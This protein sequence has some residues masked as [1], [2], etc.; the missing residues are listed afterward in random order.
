MTLEIIIWG[1]ILIEVG[2]ARKLFP[3]E[4]APA[5]VSNAVS[6]PSLIPPP[7]FCTRSFLHSFLHTI[8]SALSSLSPSVKPLESCLFI[9]MSVKCHITLS[10]SGSSRKCSVHL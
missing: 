7:N 9:Q 5:G 10:L 1:A 2:C 6:Y 4:L 8:S 3:R